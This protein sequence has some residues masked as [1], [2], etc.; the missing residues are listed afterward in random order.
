M[1]SN[2]FAI[3]GCVDFNEC[4]VNFGECQQ[5][6]NNH[7]GGFSCSC[8][9]GYYLDEVSRAQCYGESRVLCVHYY[10]QLV[11]L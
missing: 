1:Y 9:V 5:V 6:C 4:A 11:F 2:C 7:I 8:W 3:V 10:D